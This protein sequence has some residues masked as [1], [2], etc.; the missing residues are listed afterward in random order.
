[1]VIGSVS[2]RHKLLKASAATTHGVTPTS[3]KRERYGTAAILSD[4]A[5]FGKLA[6]CS[7][8]WQWDAFFVGPR[9]ERDRE[10]RET[11][12]SVSRSRRGRRYQRPPGPARPAGRTPRKGPIRRA[13][14]PRSSCGGAFR[15]ERPSKLIVM[16]RKTGSSRSNSRSSACQRMRMV[17]PRAWAASRPAVT[18]KSRQ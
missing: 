5:R 13:Q 15:C 4:L 7:R 18:R 10:F 11:L 1:M 17:L 3:V 2:E 16:A 12:N 6:D 14:R 9:A 8:V